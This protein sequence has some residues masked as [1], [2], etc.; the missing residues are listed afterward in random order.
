MTR[1][2]DGSLKNVAINNPENLSQFGGDYV[3]MTV[4]N[5][6][7]AS[8]MRKNNTKIIYGKLEKNYSRGPKTDKPFVSASISADD[9][10]RS[11]QDFAGSDSI[12]PRLGFYSDIQQARK[13]KTPED[14]KIAA[15]TVI[16]NR[17]VEPSSE[18]L[19]A[20]QNTEPDVPSSPAGVK[21]VET[22]DRM[23]SVLKGQAT[24]ESLQ[25]TFSEIVSE[26]LSNIPGVSKEALGRIKIL[27]LLPQETVMKWMQDPAKVTMKDV[28]NA[29]LT[30]DSVFVKHASDQFIRPYMLEL[31]GF[32]DG[33]LNTTLA[34]PVVGSKIASKPEK[35]NIFNVADEVNE[36]LRPIYGEDVI[37][38]G[39]P[40]NLKANKKTASF[41]KG[42]KQLPTIQAEPKMTPEAPANIK[43][44]IKVMKPVIEKQASEQLVPKEPVPKEPVNIEYTEAGKQRLKEVGIATKESP[45]V[46]DTEIALTASSRNTEVP[47]T[48]ATE[49]QISERLNRQVPEDMIAEVTP[50]EIESKNFT[51]F[52]QGFNVGAI[53]LLSNAQSKFDVGS[54][55]WKK[56]ELAKSKV[57]K[58]DLMDGVK[59]T[60]EQNLDANGKPDIGK[61]FIEFSKNYGEWL[62]SQ[63]A[64]N[65]FANKNSDESRALFHWF[66]RNS[67]PIQRQK[68]VL[69][70]NGKELSESVVTSTETEP[71]SHLDN[72]V[73]ET[74]QTEGTQMDLLYL[75]PSDAK[76]ALNRDPQAIFSR[77]KKKGYVVLG[78][79]GNNLN[80]LFGIKL[81]KKLIDRF[82]TKSEMYLNKGESLKADEDKFIRVFMVDVLGLPKDASY[83]AVLKRWK[84][85]NSHEV[86]NAHR[87]NDGTIPT[88]KQTI[89]ESPL[90]D[91]GKARYDGVIYVTEETAKTILQANGMDSNIKWIKP[92]FVSKINGKMILQKGE[93]KVAGGEDIVAIRDLIGRD[94]EPNEF[95]SFNDNVKIGK[96]TGAWNYEMP[97]TDMRLE[98]H[99][100]HK[101]E[102]GFSFSN[103][104]KY[105][106]SDNSVEGL[107]NNYHKQIQRWN[108]FNK[109]LLAAKDADAIRAV[110]D[111]Y[112]DYGISESGQWEKIQNMMGNSAGVD[113]LRKEIQDQS[114]KVLTDYVLA[115]RWI[116]GDHLRITPSTKT[117]W[118]DPMTGKLTEE[119]FLNTDEIAMSSKAWKKAGSPEFV[120]AYRSPTT[121]KTAMIKAKV[122]LVDNAN[123]GDEL[124]MLSHDDVFNRLEGDYDGDA[125]RFAVLGDDNIPMAMADSIQK[126][127]EE[128]GDIMLPELTAYDKKYVTANTLFNGA[129]SGIRGGDEIGIIASTMRVM[130]DL[131]ASGIKIK[132][133]KPINGKSKM[134]VYSKKD[135]VIYEISIKNDGT[136]EIKS[137]TPKWES[138]TQ[139]DNAQYLAALMSQEATDSQKYQNLSKRLY[140]AE[141]L[142]LS[143]TGE[144]LIGKVFD[145]DDANVIKGINKFIQRL[146]TPYK[147]EGEKFSTN[148]E[149]FNELS[150]YLELTSK[151]RES[152]GDIGWN[153]KIVEAIKDTQPISQL[154]SAIIFKQ[155]SAGV[156]AVKKLA[157]E[158]NVKTK[159]STIIASNKVIENFTRLV[160]E[161]RFEIEFNAWKQNFARKNGEAITVE[162]SS[163]LRND[164]IDSYNAIKPSLT[165]E[166]DAALKYWLITDDRANLRNTIINNAE[167]NRYEKEMAEFADSLDASLDGEV[168]P[169][170]RRNRSQFQKG[171]VWRLDDIF[172]AEVNP[173]AQAYY[174]GKRTFNPEES[175]QL[176]SNLEFEANKTIE[177]LRRR[178]NGAKNQKNFPIK[179]I[180][181]LKEKLKGTVE[182]KN[183]AIASLKDIAKKL[184]RK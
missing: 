111:K 166:E 5:D 172:A 35:Q 41:Q 30:S 108:E 168:I 29:F 66:H 20:I 184:N 82:D 88:Y 97:A 181:E 123:L 90:G 135:R 77:F 7:I 15:D 10:T 72:L 156:T 24:P 160:D 80:D 25:R 112:D 106:S 182:E 179:R 109:E 34:L 18:L 120:L 143:N 4:D 58:K 85:L 93:I 19:K 46:L 9:L 101:V 141:Q 52:N 177:A 142:G 114:S 61:S 132:V 22:F 74:N 116:K 70:R 146:Q 94:L 63:G 157:F 98:Y 165:T 113:D 129:L 174:E 117:R 55:E 2:E 153:G 8:W 176:K 175:L 145:I 17:E 162:S 169:D 104:S 47:E 96:Q 43:E 173:M 161:K 49:S 56:I 51:E 139:E 12:S 13:A 119:R 148:E 163:K 50:K 131:V 118:K 73:K 99:N 67:D 134:T 140:A 26:H 21:T 76:F 37:G 45:D 170:Y 57:S 151:L 36:T 103:L 167:K 78:A 158:E 71:T 150:S 59:K 32:S 130:N 39:M 48:G 38:V 65:P 133:S 115:G 152:G 127:R 33:L 40:E 128:F 95:L 84:E 64:K 60:I 3:E 42:M 138:G 6:R 23:A 62:N 87:S 27:D 180:N 149:M 11:L 91:N 100:P 68:L 125:I 81:D 164:I 124:V 14:A 178:Y 86:T 105:S 31:A 16:Q 54:P 183:I 44:T 159:Y 122:V 155:D 136:G 1:L 144:I 110:Y 83:G 92:T 126:D 89:I 28:F 121:R 75:D 154:N 147:L 107:K 53:K 171:Q 79:S 137:L 69:Q 102:G